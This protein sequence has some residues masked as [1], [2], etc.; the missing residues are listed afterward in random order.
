MAR[1]VFPTPN[2]SSSLS[3][4]GRVRTS[5]VI[6]DKRPNKLTV[7]GVVE[8]ID[9]VLNLGNRTRW[10]TSFHARELCSQVTADGASDV[11]TARTSLSQN[12][13]KIVGWFHGC[14]ISVVS[15]LMFICY[16]SVPANQ[17]A[18]LLDAAKR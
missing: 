17:H 1:R 13:L 4:G 7:I 14:D 16:L 11:T 18:I 8:A 2:V 10:R 6:G 9:A 5:D 15:P 3:R 12:G